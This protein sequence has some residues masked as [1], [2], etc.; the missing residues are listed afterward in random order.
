MSSQ[1][2]WETSEPEP[3]LPWNSKVTN[4]CVEVEWHQN[5]SPE[6]RGSSK[7]IVSPT[8]TLTT[9]DDDSWDPSY[10]HIKKSAKIPRP[11]PPKNVENNIEVELSFDERTPISNFQAPKT[12]RD[13]IVQTEVTYAP[14]QETSLFPLVSTT[15]QETIP[16]Q[17]RS[18]IPSLLDIEPDENGKFSAP[19]AI[20][21]ENN[22]VKETNNTNNDWN[23][24]KKEHPSNKIVEWDNPEKI[25][26][27]SKDIRDVWGSTYDR[28]KKDD[29]RNQEDVWGLG[30][31]HDR[32]KKDDRR[33]QEDVWGLG[34]THDLG[35]KDDRRN[36]EAPQISKDS[37]DV[38]T[39]SQ[40]IDEVNEFNNDRKSVPK[41]IP[42][43][44][45]NRQ[46]VFKI[47]KDSWD[48]NADTTKSTDLFPAPEDWTK[49]AALFVSQITDSVESTSQWVEKQQYTEKNYYDDFSSENKSG[50]SGRNEGKS[51]ACYKCNQEGHIARDCPESG[52][53]GGRNEGLCYKC[54]ESGHIARECPNVEDS[55]RRDFGACY[56]C[57]K[58]GHKAAEC[59]EEREYEDIEGSGSNKKFTCF[60]CGSPDHLAIKCPSRQ[61]QKP[62]PW[63][64][65]N[66][67][68]LTSD[69]AWNKLLQADK[70]RDV[71]D[72][73][74]AFEEYAK[75]SSELTF[76]EIERQLRASNCKGRLVAL[77]REELPLTKCLVDL[78][79]VTEDKKY[80]VQI[81]MG[82]PSRLARTAGR[83]AGS[84]EEN[85][86][87]LSQ[88][89]FLRDDVVPTC[90]NCKKKGHI[91]KECQEPRRDRGGG[92]GRGRDCYNC[93]STEHQA[94]ECDSEDRGDGQKGYRSQT[95]HNCGEEGHFSRDCTEP[96]R[97]GGGGGD[98]Q[99]GYRS[100]TC[101]NCGEE[102]HFSRD[103]TEP[104]RSGG[105]GRKCHKCGEEGHLARDCGGDDYYDNKKYENND[106][107]PKDDENLGPKYALSRGRNQDRDSSWGGKH[108]KDPSFGDK[109][110]RYWV[111]KQ[112]RNAPWEVKQ[113]ED[114]SY[115][116]KRDLSRSG[117][118]DF[119]REGYQNNDNIQPTWAQNKETPKS[120]W[121]LN[122]N[123]DEEFGSSGR[124]NKYKGKESETPFIDEQKK[125]N[126][127][128]TT[129]KSTP[130]KI[131]DW[132]MKREPVSPTP[133][134]N[135]WDSP[136]R[137]NEKPEMFGDWNTRN[138][139]K[140]SRNESRTP[141]FSKKSSDG[142]GVEMQDKPWWE[143]T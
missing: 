36:R 29:R 66:P 76:Q 88:A 80:V 118:Q 82:P 74:D 1:I 107:W 128:W 61:L 15:V 41:E 87:W 77:E 33:N 4:E 79:G 23:K 31:T 68:N 3:T 28:S 140:L 131:D 110:G 127:I 62:S 93:G 95:C 123:K 129:E 9:S 105:G 54:N 65:P 135:I 84:D 121:G 51:G 92:G 48:N 111:G 18:V 138:S 122:Q 25:S 116:D 39:F 102:G 117:K 99:K 19:S 73:K 112:D 5:S 26:S 86:E 141:T 91:T 106:N 90:F 56:K 139:N 113:Y 67:T 143:N 32:G 49:K 81:V 22:Y 114:P 75:S 104:R 124:P 137:R 134:S 21:L 2:N 24:P 136:S 115:G 12:F 11:P 103:C 17:L 83:R 58:P 100:Q 142:R 59:T 38:T 97:S 52:R 96:R 108:D 7:K 63:D 70:E 69:E 6:T 42:V 8:R 126:D 46:E 44:N 14:L 120:N 34:I 85:I 78:Q 20:S 101:H 71:D 53:S 50:R 47:A 130:I 30:I 98:G 64:N 10:E 94:R 89:G 40:D 119:L 55:G 132:S 43:S 37:W 57:H 27:F 35:N 72:F 45:E 16:N 125:S 13:V 133:R 60:V 109:E